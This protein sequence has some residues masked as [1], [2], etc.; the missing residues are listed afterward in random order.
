M[1]L[2][3]VMG[4]MHKIMVVVEDQIL[5][6][7]L[8]V[9]IMEVIVERI[10]VNLQV[11]ANIRNLGTIITM[12]NQIFLI[13]GHLAIPLIFTPQVSILNLLYILIPH[14]GS[15]GVMM[16]III[17]IIILGLIELIFKI[18]MLYKIVLIYIY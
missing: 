18:F 1:V 11:A 14:R 16:I 12:A 9:V 5:V 7:L 2:A 17:H 6:L 3:L 13:M 15:L 10:K 8:V 4:V